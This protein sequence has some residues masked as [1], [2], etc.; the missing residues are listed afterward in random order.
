MSSVVIYRCSKFFSAEMWNYNLTTFLRAHHLFI[1]LTALVTA[2]GKLVSRDGTFN[3]LSRVFLANFFLTFRTDLVTRL[4]SSIQGRGL[5][6][7]SVS[8]TF[9]HTDWTSMFFHMFKGSGHNS[10]ATLHVNYKS[11]Q[12]DKYNSM[13]QNVEDIY[14]YIYIY[15]EAQEDCSSLL[16]PLFFLLS[17]T[18][19]P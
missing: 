16:P 7:S 14:I 15:I 3:R 10:N 5:R 13:M 17:S 11:H 6:L 2:Y 1:T 4:K 8:V 12:S 19:F 18:L 9:N